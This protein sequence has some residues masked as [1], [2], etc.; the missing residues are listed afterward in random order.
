MVSPGIVRRRGVWPRIHPSFFPKRYICSCVYLRR[1]T[2]RHQ[3]LSMYSELVI[4]LY[5][6]APPFPDLLDRQVPLRV[7][8]GDRPPRPSLSNG[9]S[10][11]DP[12]WSLTQACWNHTVA[13]RPPADTVA[14]TLA[15][16]INH[17]DA[18]L[19]P[20]PDTAVNTLATKVDRQF[21]IA[22]PLLPV[23]MLATS[24]NHHQIMTPPTVL[25]HPCECCTSDSSS[26]TS[27]SSIF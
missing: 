13:A 24:V 9:T 3:P 4:Q 20:P 1:G 11:S 23:M 26:S 6:G 14:A 8:Q 19:P 7:V 22:T 10:I 21:S 12:L 5:T 25:R 18:T 17:E 2:R 27:S 16:V 15:R